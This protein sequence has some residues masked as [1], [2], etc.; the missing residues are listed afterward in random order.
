[1]YLYITAHITHTECANSLYW[2]PSEEILDAIDVHP[3]THLSDIPQREHIIN[4]T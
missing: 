3:Q 4:Y 2:F 1:M